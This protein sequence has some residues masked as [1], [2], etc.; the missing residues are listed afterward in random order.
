MQWNLEN[1][2]NLLVWA[3]A[4]YWGKRRKN[5]VPAK[6][7]IGE[8]SEPSSVVVPTTKLASLTVIFPTNVFHPFFLAFSP[9]TEPAWSQATNL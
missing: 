9:T 2:T 3:Q 4:P 6:K 5:S 8:Q 1:T 7:K